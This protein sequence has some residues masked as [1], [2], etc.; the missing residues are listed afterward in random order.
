MRE[1]VLYLMMAV[2]RDAKRQVEDHQRRIWQRRLWSTLYGKTAV[3]VGTGIVGA[4]IGEMLQ[5]LGMRVVGVTPH[6][7]RKCAASTR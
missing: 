5:A 7:A 3:I 6:A 2:S 4:A 1:Q